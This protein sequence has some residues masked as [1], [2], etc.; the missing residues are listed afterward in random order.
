MTF[1]P[2]LSILSARTENATAFDQGLDTAWQGSAGSNARRSLILAA[3]ACPLKENVLGRRLEL[4]EKE[5]PLTSNLVTAL[6]L[7]DHG[8]LSWERQECW[9]N[10][11]FLLATLAHRSPG[12]NFIAAILC[13]VFPNEQLMSVLA[14]QLSVLF[15]FKRGRGPFSDFTANLL[16]LHDEFNVF[17]AP[18]K[19]LNEKTNR[20]ME[21][22]EYVLARPEISRFIS[23]IRRRFRGR[24]QVKLRTMAPG[25]VTEL[26]QFSGG[27]RGAE[28]SAKS[29]WSGI[30]RDIE[31]RDWMI[32][33]VVA[34]LELSPEAIWTEALRMR[35]LGTMRNRPPLFKNPPISTLREGDY[36][37]AAIWLLADIW[38]YCFHG[39]VR[40]ENLRYSS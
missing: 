35:L 37:R 10:F 39:F 7:R 33:I 8:R 24:S 3:L 13:R 18:W 11:T 31:L 29:A 27:L 5:D 14:L 32:K 26:E 30:Q 38:C 28:R 2:M 19:L 16:T 40:P 4:F 1:L 17:G 21:H 15:S 34:G 22:N 36:I 6:L 20:S 23:K 25:I 12:A 9:K